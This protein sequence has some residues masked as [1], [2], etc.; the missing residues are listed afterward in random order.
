MIFRCI[1]LSNILATTIQVQLNF[2]GQRTSCP[3]GILCSWNITDERFSTL[4]WVWRLSSICSIVMSSSRLK[5]PDSSRLI[6]TLALRPIS[7]GC[8]GR[9]CTMPTGAII[10]CWGLHVKYLTPC[11]DPSFRP[12]GSSNST[13]Q[14]R[15]DVRLISP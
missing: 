9:G 6:F 12:A 14:N 2:S 10:P 13:P 5:G 4:T 8:W 11:T 15:P 3:D 7:G 1:S